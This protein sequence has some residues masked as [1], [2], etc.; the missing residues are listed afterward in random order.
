MQYSGAFQDAGYITS[1]Y[2]A[3]LKRLLELGA[4]PDLRGHQTTPLHIASSAG[5]FDVI[6]EL[7]RAGARTNDVGTPC[8]IAW[9]TSPLMCKVSSHHGASPLWICR[10]L[11]IEWPY[12]EYGAEHYQKVEKLLLTY[13]AEDYILPG[14]QPLFE[15]RHID[16]VIE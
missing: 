14:C 1:D 3:R 12:E 2:S 11:R 7:L 13:G 16:E 15:H 9:G 8:G 6:E 10:R 5:N 4:D